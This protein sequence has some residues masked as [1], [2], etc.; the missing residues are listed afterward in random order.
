LIEFLNCDIA[1]FEEVEIL[2]FSVASGTIGFVFV[3]VV[4]L[5]NSEALIAPDATSLKLDLKELKEIDP[6]E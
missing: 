6:E 5:L 2:L 3:T 1:R 4:F